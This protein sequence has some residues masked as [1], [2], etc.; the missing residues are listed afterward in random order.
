MLSHNGTDIP[1]VEF[2]S[3]SVGY[4]Q[5]VVNT[6]IVINDY[7]D[8]VANQ[9]I[10]G[11]LSSVEDIHM[12][13]EYLSSG[14]E[15]KTGDERINKI[16]QEII[17]TIASTYQVEVDQVLSDINDILDYCADRTA[18]EFIKLLTELAP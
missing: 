4:K 18:E 12:I 3:D 16:G 13:D 17:P 1:G 6:T 7:I 9:L 14:C 2:A 10:M 11:D 15:L 8:E 5:S